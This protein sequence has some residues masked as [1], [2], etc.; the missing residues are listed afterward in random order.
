ME[1]ARSGASMRL[2]CR[3]HA[4]LIRREEREPR[5]NLAQHSKANNEVMNA[6]ADA[7]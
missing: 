4:S 2:S 7:A 6:G 1:W 5:R 3:R